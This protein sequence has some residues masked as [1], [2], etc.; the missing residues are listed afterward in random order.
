MHEIGH[1]LGLKHGHEF[2]GPANTPLTTDRDFMEFSIMTYRKY[3]E[4]PPD[5]DFFADV[6]RFGAAQTLMMYDIAA[7]QTLYG[8][9]FNA[10][11]ES[12]TYSPGA[13]LP[14]RCSSTA[15]ARAP[16]AQTASS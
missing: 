8:A 2:G 1:A 11:S 4:A 12:T 10:N 6:E 5:G 16:P 9:N 14:A 15:S 13:P 7:L 3:P